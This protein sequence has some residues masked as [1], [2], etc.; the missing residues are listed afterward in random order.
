MSPSQSF[1]VSYADGGTIDVNAPDDK[2]ARAHAESV[3]VDRAAAA[4]RAGIEIPVR[5]VARV[6]T[7]D[8]N[9]ERQAAARAASGT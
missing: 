7:V 2:A 5:A 9:G 6:D 4:K 8:K 1:R 3:E